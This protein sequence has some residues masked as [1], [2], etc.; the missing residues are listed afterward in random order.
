MIKSK[1][2]VMLTLAAMAFA[3]DVIDPESVDV[4][5]DRTVKNDDFG[6]EGP[7]RDCYYIRSFTVRK[8]L[9]QDPT[10]DPS[11]QHSF[12]YYHCIECLN[13][14]LHEVREP[15][16]NFSYDDQD[17][18]EDAEPVLIALPEGCPAPI[19]PRKKTPCENGIEL[20]KHLVS[21]VTEI[22]TKEMV[23][24]PLNLEI[25]PNDPNVN[26]EKMTEV[27]VAL[28]SLSERIAD[29]LEK[30]H[31]DMPNAPD[32]SVTTPEGVHIETY[33]F[34][35]SQVVVTALGP[36]LSGT[37]PG[38]GGE[39]GPGGE[40]GTGSE[41]SPLPETF[42]QPGTDDTP[43]EVVHMPPF[44]GTMIDEN[45]NEI[46]VSPEQGLGPEQ[47]TPGLTMLPK[48]LSQM[49]PG[50]YHSK[51]VR[52][53]KDKDDPNVVTGYEIT[54]VK[55]TAD[56]RTHETKT[57]TQ[58]PNEGDEPVYTGYIHRVPAVADASRIS[59]ARYPP[60]EEP[61][62]TVVDNPLRFSQPDTPRE[63]ELSPELFSQI[64]NVAA[65]FT[66]AVESIVTEK[67]E[68]LLDKIFHQ[69]KYEIELVCSKTAAEGE[70]NAILKN[71]LIRELFCNGGSCDQVYQGWVDEMITATAEGNAAHFKIDKKTYVGE[72]TAGPAA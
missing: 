1:Y 33:T 42:P 53:I 8:K 12:I 37:E 40:T 14:D 32:S 19:L 36:D 28:N 38:T 59:E 21:D 7:T 16:V 63:V 64:G 18:K 31:D 27:T 54:E 35:N 58:G 11:M 70:K 4:V 72:L 22:V 20:G 25:D 66:D 57:W 67:A 50:T 47:T 65:G 3:V 9:E 23:E 61:I 48:D 62:I 39:P 69:K 52:T 2:I 29:E 49:K 5:S 26:T 13:I 46:H 41:P 34:P 51:K 56:P 55:I 30:F 17:L 68:C 6:G 45:G 71:E 10:K 24:N 44:S 43:V 60:A 15:Y